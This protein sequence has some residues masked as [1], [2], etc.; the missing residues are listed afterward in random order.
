M[1]NHESLIALY[2]ACCQTPPCL[3]PNRIRE[4]MVR[5][6][7]EIGEAPRHSEDDSTPEVLLHR[8]ATAIQGLLEN[9]GYFDNDGLDSFPEW[10][11]AHELSQEISNCLNR[12]G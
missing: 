4:A 11:E 2:E 7:F 9:V 6:A 12:N 5:C 10:S 1:I 8:S 3:L